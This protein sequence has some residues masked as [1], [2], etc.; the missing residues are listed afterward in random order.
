MS[1]YIKTLKAHDAARQEHDQARYTRQLEAAQAAEITAARDRLVPLDV[2]LARLLA[3]VP[4]EVQREGLSLPTLQTMLKGRRR[5]GCHPG[6]LGTA[7][8]RLGW[9]RRRCWR[10]DGDGGFAARWHPPGSA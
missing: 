8:R 1:H 3:T 5:G 7:L 4:A 10:G 9:S 2:R 6:E